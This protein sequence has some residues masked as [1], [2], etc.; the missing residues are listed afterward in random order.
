MRRFGVSTSCLLEEPLS[1]ALMLLSDICDLVEIQCDA[2]HSLFL[3]ENVCKEFDLRYTLHA[4]SGDGNIASVFEPIR[5]ASLEVIRET[6]EIGTRID[7]EML[8]IHPGFCLFPDDRDA[9]TAALLLS[10]DELGEMQRENSIRFSV[11]N[12]GFWESCMFQKPDLLVY[13][14]EC[15]LSFVLD[16][17]HVNLTQTLVPCLLA[18]PDHL[19]L[20][21]NRGTL[22]EHTACGSGTIDFSQVIAAAGSATMIVEV[23]HFGDVERSLSFLNGL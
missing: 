20:H 12:L 4:P 6:A 5:Q 17:D 18:K 21:D 1:D 14:R 13:I 3:Y 9:S 8:V 15:G 11:E 10:F 2:R 19:H 7:A 22:D 23:M 16:V